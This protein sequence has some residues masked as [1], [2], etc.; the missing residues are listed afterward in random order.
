MFVYY[1]RAHQISLCIIRLLAC[2]RSLSTNNKHS[3]TSYACSYCIKEFALVPQNDYMKAATPISSDYLG[4]NQDRNN[5]LRGIPT[6][7]YLLST[8]FLAFFPISEIFKLNRICTWDRLVL[9]P[10][11]IN[12]HIPRTVRGNSVIAHQSW[13]LRRL[14][15][16]DG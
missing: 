3:Y 13:R 10:D 1:A 5:G 4:L 9:S 7:P 14:K 11:P 12:T 16:P 6:A 15:G 2:H 8:P